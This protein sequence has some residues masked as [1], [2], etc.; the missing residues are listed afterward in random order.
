MQNLQKVAVIQYGVLGSL[1]D[2]QRLYTLMPKIRAWHMDLQMTPR[3]TR[4]SFMKY[5][6]IFKVAVS[7]IFIHWLQTARL[8]RKNVLFQMPVAP[9]VSLLS[10]SM[11]RHGLIE[12]RLHGWLS[13]WSYARGS[14]NVLNFV[15][16]ALGIGW[17][18]SLICVMNHGWMDASLGSV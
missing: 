9:K 14:Q 12:Y 3:S 5:F 10:A 18:R 1:V 7:I 8:E 13:H 11:R 6:S 15:W 2:C 16:V 17:D 4:S